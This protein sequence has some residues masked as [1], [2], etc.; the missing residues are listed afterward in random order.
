MCR[1]QTSII[2]A[3]CRKS[4]ALS[5]RWGPKT[6]KIE[7]TGAVGVHTYL[8]TDKGSSAS[9]RPWLEL[10]R[11]ASLSSSNIHVQMGLIFL[12]QVKKGE[13]VGGPVPA[14]STRLDLLPK[15]TFSM[16]SFRL[17]EWKHL[18]AGSAKKAVSNGRYI[19]NSANR[20]V[21]KIASISV[22]FGGDGQEGIQPSDSLVDVADG[23]EGSE[24][25][26]AVCE[27]GGVGWTDWVRALLTIMVAFQVDQPQL[28]QFT[29]ELLWDYGVEW[30]EVYE[31]HSHIWVCWVC[32]GRGG[33]RAEQIASSVD[34]LAQYAKVKGSRVGG[35]GWTWCVTWL[36]VQSTS[37]WWGSVQQGDSHWSKE[38]VSL[39]QV[40]WW[41]P[42]NVM[43]Q[44]QL[45]SE[46]L[47]TSVK[48]SLS[49]S[50]SFSTQP[51]H[52][53][54]TS[55]IFEVANL[56]V[57]GRCRCSFWPLPLK[58]HWRWPMCGNKLLLLW[59][60]F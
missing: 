33:W 19:C 42:W 53:L 16:L 58:Q 14:G 47:K 45:V 35:G 7:G 18:L 51:C 11:W 57:I 44:K 26:E 41:W 34:R 55:A 48:T 8:G 15:S 52:S 9:S 22:C 17:P 10:R 12:W 13:G 5:A 49:S 3:L 25:I 36:T 20:T 4:I 1:L 29:T 39:A 50:A 32:W 60:Q 59:Q 27:S 54:R 43:K 30:T 23:R 24:F 46:V 38:Q 6:E 37:W 40:W 2:H 56:S 31:Q 28:V 21:S